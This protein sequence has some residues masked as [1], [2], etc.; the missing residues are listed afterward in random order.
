MEK[1]ILNSLK[2]SHEDIYKTKDY[3]KQ[4]LKKKYHGDVEKTSNTDVQKGK[5]ILKPLANM[6]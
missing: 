5:L 4:F 6:I 2:V 1:F 3:Y